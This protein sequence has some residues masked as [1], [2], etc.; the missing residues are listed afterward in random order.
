MVSGDGRRPS[1]DN[2][3]KTQKIYHKLSANSCRSASLTVKPSKHQAALRAALNQKIAHV[4]PGCG[5]AITITQLNFCEFA[6]RVCAASGKA[7]NLF[8][9]MCYKAAHS[10]H[11]TN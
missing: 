2:P 1:Q 8:V 5:Y 3:Q 7:W 6:W 4:Y 11:N 10:A 9:A